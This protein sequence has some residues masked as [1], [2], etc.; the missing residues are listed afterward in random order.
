MLPSHSPTLPLLVPYPLP[1]LS[2]TPSQI[3]TMVGDLYPTASERAPILAAI[4]K[5]CG[6][7]KSRAGT[8]GNWDD[9]KDHRGKHKGSGVDAIEKARL[10][11][12]AYGL[13]HTSA[14]HGVAPLRP[15]RVCP[16][17]KTSRLSAPSRNPSGFVSATPAAPL[18]APETPNA[19]AEVMMQ[20]QQ[21]LLTLH[22]L[23]RQVAGGQQQMATP[24]R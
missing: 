7:P 24:V 23:Q 4:Q 8:E 16:P 2:H 18:A 10:D 20:Q 6:P 5:H 19:F 17:L 15:E 21:Q 12:A 22:L 1:W 9:W 11:P 3:Q 14:I 13:E